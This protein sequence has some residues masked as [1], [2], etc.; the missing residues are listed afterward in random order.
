MVTAINNVKVQRLL[1]IASKPTDV[2][3]SLFTVGHVF[4][5]AKYTAIQG[6]VSPHLMAFS[7]KSGTAFS[8]IWTQTLDVDVIKTNPNMAAIPFD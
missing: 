2:Q 8:S 5:A 1:K 6:R 3:F 7:S 4:V